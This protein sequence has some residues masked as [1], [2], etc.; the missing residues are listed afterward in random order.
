MGGGGG[1][2]VCVCVLRNMTSHELK[3]KVTLNVM[4]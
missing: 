2:C 4:L 3:I 1:R